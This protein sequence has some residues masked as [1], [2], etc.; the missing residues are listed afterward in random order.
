MALSERPPI[1]AVVRRNYPG[2]DHPTLGVFHGGE[3]VVEAYHSSSS[4]NFYLEGVGKMV[5]MPRRSSW[6]LEYFDLV[7]LPTEKPIEPWWEKEKT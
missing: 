3:Y 7:S 6:S 2:H 4:Q 5:G 1:G